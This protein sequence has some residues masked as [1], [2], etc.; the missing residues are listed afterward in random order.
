MEKYMIVFILIFY[1]INS[2][3]Q[4]NKERKLESWIKENNIVFNS[5][6]S[7][8]GFDHFLKCNNVHAYR[9][10]IGD[11]IIIYSRGDAIAENVETLSKSIKK[12]EFNVFRY[13]SYTQNNGTIVVQELRKWTFLFR[14]DTLYLLD[15]Y[16]DEKTTELI[17]TML[18]SNKGKMPKPDF[19]KEPKEIK[20]KD[21]GFRPQFKMIYYKGIFK[22]N[23]EYVFNKN[24]NF[25]EE[26]VNLIRSWKQNEKQYFEIN[27]VTNTAGR[28]VL[29]DDLTFINTEDCKK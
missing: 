8:E 19:T 9:K 27:L 25:R 10:N 3:S 24:Q 13:P 29:S 11:T 6:I 26:K 7:P 17:K 22:K 23:N 2:F 1:N 14:K 4:P 5:P 20:S 12:T 21:L 16:D 28:Y 15:E 18:A